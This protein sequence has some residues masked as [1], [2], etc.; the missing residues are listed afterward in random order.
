M[1][2]RLVLIAELQSLGHLCKKSRGGKRF[3]P[4]QSLGQLGCWILFHGG[5]LSE[6]GLWPR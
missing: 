4:R 5:K 1:L 6:R 2:G 3:C